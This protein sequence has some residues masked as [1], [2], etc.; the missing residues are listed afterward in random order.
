MPPSVLYIE[1]KV[2][3]I[4]GSS[5]GLFPSSVNEADWMESLVLTISSGYVKKTDVMPARPPQTRRVK[6][7]RSAPGDV[8][9]IF[10]QLYHDQ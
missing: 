6:E 1:T 5:F 8:S 4:P 9:K 3:H 2:D 7:D 10:C